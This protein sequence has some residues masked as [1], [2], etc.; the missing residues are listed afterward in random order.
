M[1]SPFFGSNKISY[2]K[3][4]QQNDM[5]IMI[6]SMNILESSV[7]DRLRQLSKNYIS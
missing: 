3:K 4:R 7:A 6:V 5:V 1:H 2:M